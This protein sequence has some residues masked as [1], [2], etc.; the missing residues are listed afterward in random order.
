MRV[1]HPEV[2]DD[3]PGSLYVAACGPAWTSHYH[4]ARN[5]M[6]LI[7]GLLAELY[8]QVPPWI[9][10]NSDSGSHSIVSIVPSRGPHC[11]PHQTRF[12]PV[13]FVTSLQHGK[14]PVNQG[15]VML[16]LLKDKNIIRFYNYTIKIIIYF[17]IF[18]IIYIIMICNI[19]QS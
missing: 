4:Q 12:P 16:K 17:L 15:P 18:I 3:G 8:L 14:A 9:P 6:R 2:S 1:P 13:Y 11:L 19:F 10:L 7:L 5:L